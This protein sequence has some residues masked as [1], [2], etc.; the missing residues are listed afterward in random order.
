MAEART[1]EIELA[2]FREEQ[3]KLTDELRGAIE[4]APTKQSLEDVY[5]PYK[6]KRRTRAQSARE[7]GLEPLADAL[8]ADPTLD[9]EQEGAKYVNVKPGTDGS[10]AINIPDAKTALEGAP[11]HSGRALCRDVSDN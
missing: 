4:T 8:L 5:L 1:S 7:A 9:P 10:D 6:P 3:G 11:R 2:S